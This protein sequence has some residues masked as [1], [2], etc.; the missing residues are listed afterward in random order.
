MSFLKRLFG[1]NDPGNRPNQTAQVDQFNQEWFAAVKRFPIVAQFN[2]FRFDLKHP[3]TGDIMQP[4]EGIA[5][6]F[7]D[8][9][10]VESPWDRRRLLFELLLNAVGRSLKNWQLANILVAI[11]RP[12]QAISLFNQEQA[13]PPDSEDYADYCEAHARALQYLQRPQEAIEWAQKAHTAAKDNKT[14]QLR[15]ADAL[16]MTGEC[17]KG[18]AIYSA[19]MKDAPPSKAQTEEHVKHMFDTLFSLES[20]AVP[21]PVFAIDIG[22]KL[23]DPQQVAEFWQLAEI[24]FYDSPYFRMHHAYYHLNHGDIPRAMAKLLTLVQ[25]MPWLREPS[26]NL[27]LLFK[28]LDPTGTK[29]MPEFQ[30]QLRQYIKKNGWTTEDMRALDFNLGN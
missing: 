20:G 29:M 12:D 14:I 30:Q 28:K 7:E 5:G 10:Q 1:K 26:I 6:T 3:D 25:E 21:S 23:S 15:L 19:R 11:R 27:D 4:H 8:W 24:E 17:D 16:I 13:P 9:L 18:H 22:E 2:N